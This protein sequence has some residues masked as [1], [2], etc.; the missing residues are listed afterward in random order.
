MEQLLLGVLLLCLF[1]LYSVCQQ[2]RRKRQIS[3]GQFAQHHATTEKNPYEA[4]E[5]LQDFDW[6]TTP[7]IRN[8]PLKPK[9]HLTMG[10]SAIK[11]LE[12]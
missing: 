7:P 11:R 1:V 8:A 9:Y 4:I 6:S 12:E 2:I 3:Q 5:P 10:E